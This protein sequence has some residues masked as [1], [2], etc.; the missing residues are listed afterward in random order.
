MV[1]F[2]LIFKILQY[3]T[4][5]PANRPLS[6]YIDLSGLDLDDRQK[7]LLQIKK[8]ENL[9]ITTSLEINL[10]CIYHCHNG[11]NESNC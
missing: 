11:R 1:V 10:I 7:K 3:V 6:I 2:I 8:N 4:M 9:I 5:A